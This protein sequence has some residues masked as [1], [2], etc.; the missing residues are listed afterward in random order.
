M[1]T[2]FSKWILFISSYIPLYSIF[3]VSNIF[4]IYNKYTKLKNKKNF[5]IWML[6][7]NA[8]NNVILIIIFL[9]II[10]LALIMILILINRCCKN[11]NYEEVKNIK[12]N[13]KSI[14][15]YVLVYILPFISIQS[16]DFKQLTIFL[17]VFSIIGVVSVRNDLV[18]VNPILYFMNYNIYTFNNDKSDVSNILITKY[19]I[20]E[21]KTLSKSN[22]NK[23]LNIRISKISDN[24][25]LVG[26]KPKE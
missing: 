22:D 4:D 20:L 9:A 13:N 14:N 7:Q 21:L 18:Y 25:Y 24:V 11:S 16:N 1:I 26:S 3:I 17:M 12:K 8:K 5:D 19:T 6:I 23:V 15:D 10:I 2:R